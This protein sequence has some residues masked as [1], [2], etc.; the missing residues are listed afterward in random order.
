MSYKCMWTTKR[1][2]LCEYYS[3]AR[4]NKGTTNH[5]RDWCAA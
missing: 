5:E 3:L 1:T 4:L 2:G